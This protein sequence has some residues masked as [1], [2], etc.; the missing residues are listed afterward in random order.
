MAKQS[1]PCSPGCSS[2]KVAGILVDRVFRE[3]H[4]NQVLAALT[5]RANAQTCY[6]GLALCV[7]EGRRCYQ[8]QRHDRHLGQ[9]AVRFGP[10]GEPALVASHESFTTRADGGMD[11]S[12]YGT[13][14]GGSTIVGRR[15]A[16]DGALEGVL[17][18]LESA[19]EA[20][21]LFVIAS[22]GQIADVR[23]AALV[24]APARG[25][26]GLLLRGRRRSRP[27]AATR[28]SCCALAAGAAAR[29]WTSMAPALAIRGA[30]GGA[31]AYVAAPQDVRR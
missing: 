23:S 15:L 26:G 12:G 19:D 20:A 4:T 27:A 30:A 7:P 1:P 9:R 5:R 8:G 18:S 28:L 2:P 17:L 13:P 24:H 29:C 21:R 25:G 14:E 22:L 11:R 10:R 3:S 16:V 6:S 31:P